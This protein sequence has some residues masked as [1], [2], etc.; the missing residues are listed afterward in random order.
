MYVSIELGQ[1]AVFE[2]DT[3][4][5]L[6]K[7]IYVHWA[8]GIRSSCETLLKDGETQCMGLQYYGILLLRS[9]QLP[10]M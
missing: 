5:D 2:A 9:L 1:G 7:K 6:G 10:H 3:Y 8:L 4:F